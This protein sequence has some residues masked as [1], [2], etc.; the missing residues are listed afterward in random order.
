M[1]II[2]FFK[3]LLKRKR[4]ESSEKNDNNN[5]N[6]RRFRFRNYK[7]LKSKSQYIK[8]LP[9]LGLADIPSI[10]TELKGGNIV[11]LN[12]SHF[13]QNPENKLR[14]LKRAV[15]QLSYISKIHEGEIAQLG[16]KYIL[17]TPSPSIKIWK[18]KLQINY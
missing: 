8:A 3:K 15:D 6:S 16:D 10:Q 2:D 14:E 11:I 18:E 17:M 9:L 7:I 4:E 12:I 5:G 1:K 13:I